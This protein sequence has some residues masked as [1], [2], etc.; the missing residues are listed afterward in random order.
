MLP[1]NVINT[2]YVASEVCSN[3]TFEQL[4]PIVNY[5]NLGPVPWSALSQ[6]VTYSNL[7]PPPINP[8]FTMNFDQIL[9][10]PTWSQLQTIVTYQNLGTPPCSHGIQSELL[11]NVR[12]QDLTGSCT[13]S[14][15]QSA[16][17]DNHQLGDISFR[18]FIFRS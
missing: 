2:P 14:Q 11:S 3:L 13:W 12:I 4:S 7:G 10:S 9:G 16:V 18:L 17:L 6:A 5:S 1:L 15:V 8:I